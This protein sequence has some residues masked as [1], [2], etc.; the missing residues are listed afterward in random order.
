MEASE[1]A[2]SSNS[3]SGSSPVLGQTANHNHNH[4]EDLKRRHRSSQSDDS[5]VSAKKSGSSSGPI[6]SSN[7]G[8]SSA[9]A[10]SSTTTSTTTASSVSSPLPLPAPARPVSST[11]TKTSGPPQYS[12]S[13]SPNNSSPSSGGVTALMAGLTNHLQTET[14]RQNFAQAAAPTQNGELAGPRWPPAVLTLPPAGHPSGEIVSE[15]VAVAGGLTGGLTGPASS[16]PP[17]SP[18]LSS[19]S[20][21][22]QFCKL[23]PVV[24]GLP[25][26]PVSL[27]QPGSYP[28]PGPQAQ[29][30]GG[31]VQN[32]QE[33]LQHQQKVSAE[34][35][36]LAIII[37]FLNVSVAT[38]IFV[39]F[40]ISGS[41]S[42]GTEQ[43]TSR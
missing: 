8:L 25:T 29:I 28:H 32:L 38:R 6:S 20:S 34:Q 39:I 5:K 24:A 9:P 17:N 21:T 33:H 30:N 23:E 31:L 10:T 13:Q 3:V 43:P 27:P 42:L 1:T 11:P 35:H 15:A 22:F 14:Q 16:S 2:S 41:A 4:Q 7:G 40:E 37:T 18:S 12:L 26:S 36:F 19:S